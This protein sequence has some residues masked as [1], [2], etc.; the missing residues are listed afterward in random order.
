MITTAKKKL[1]IFVFTI[2]FAIPAFLAAGDKQITPEYLDTLTVE[3]LKALPDYRIPLNQR[4]NSSMLENKT[5]AELKLLRNSI[6][7]QYGREFKTKYIRNYFLSRSWYKP[8][9]FSDSM[10][11]SN[12]KINVRLVQI[13]ESENITYTDN[14]VMGAKKCKYFENKTDT[15]SQYKIEFSDDHTLKFIEVIFYYGEEEVYEYNGAWRISNGNIEFK[16]SE[17]DNWRQLHFL[18]P[19]RQCFP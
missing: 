15:D 19:S 1:A 9:K 13:K 17:N 3:Q 5:A 16:K 11:T 8:G 7:A 12:D 6:F 18:I 4:M 10:L 2:S 14:M